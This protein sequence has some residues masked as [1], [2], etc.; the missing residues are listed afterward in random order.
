MKKQLLTLFAAFLSLTCS[1]QDTSDAA[2]FFTN[3]AWGWGTCTNEAGS[4][5]TLNGGM[6]AEQPKTIVLK[7]NGSNDGSAIMSAISSYDIIVLDGSNGPFT[8]DG[9]M[10][11]SNQKNKTIVGRNGAELATKFFLTPEDITYLKAQ[12]LEGLSSSDQYTGTLPD[13]NTLTC[14]KRAFFTKKAIEELMYKR[15][16]KYTLPNNAG[17]FQ[18]DKDCENI[19]VRNLTLRGPGAVDIDGSDLL[20]DAYAKH[21]W[22]DHCTFIDSQDGA[23]DTRGSYNTY[24]WNHF[25]YTERSFSHAY[26]C[27]LGWVKDHSDVLYVTWG[28]NIWGQGCQRRLPQADDCYLHLVNN[29]HNCAGNSEGM[30]INSYAK[31]LVEGNYAASGVKNPLTGSGANRYVTARENSFYYYS[32]STEV[33]VP[34]AYEKISYSDVPTV[35]TAKHG[36]GAT[37]DD[38]LYMPCVEPELN[39]NTFGFSESE[40]TVG[41]GRSIKLALKNLLGVECTVTSSNEDVVKIVNE[42]NATAVGAGEAIVTATV[43]DAVFGKYTATLKVTVDG[44]DDSGETVIYYHPGTKANTITFSDGAKLQITGNTGKTLDPATAIAYDGKTYS[45]IKLSNGAQN[46]FTAPA[47]KNP[48]TKVT[49]YSYINAESTSTRTSFWKEVDGEDYSEKFTQLES[50]KDASN[51]DVVSFSVSGKN[52]FT[53][54]NSGD[55]LCFIMEVT[56]SSKTPVF[57]SFASKTPVSNDVYSVSGTL[58]IKNASLTQINALP[59][60]LYIIGGKAIA[61]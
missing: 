28:Y 9:Q 39:A 11:I 56:Y 49:F 50:Y 15:N 25:Y 5:Y 16:G 22:V 60:G 31:A 32:G 46:T 42:G 6:A 37:L 8:I 48:I 57:Q 13:G 1:A 36:A 44:D 2:N 10:K 52:A 3:T 26:T 43:N 55:Q 17:I 33:T 54:T 34:Y 58:L 20:Y 47:G 45:S 35:L 61:K 53:F 12:N 23:L 59:K 21:L 24:T 30:T 19:I 18:F 29:Y 40:M 27:G 41:V 38:G 4:S 51:P 14:D 7:S